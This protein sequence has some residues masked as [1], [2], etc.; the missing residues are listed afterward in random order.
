MSFELVYTSARHGLREGAS[1]FC[2]VAATDGIPRALHEKLES[3]SGYSH[4]EAAAGAEPPVNHSHLTIRIQRNI[5][6]IVSRIGDAGIDYTGRTN[7]IAHHLALSGAEA[8]RLSHGPAALFADYGFWYADWDGEPETFS[9]NRIPSSHKEPVDDFG[10]WTEVFGDAGW[11]G[12]LGHAVANGLKS[13]SIIVPNPDV[14]MMLLHE[15]LLLVSPSDRWKVCF[16]TYFSR[17]APG[18]QCHWRFVLD[19]TSEA[20]KLRARSL[21]LLVDPRGSTGDPPDGNP[22]V[23]AARDNEPGRVHSV[24]RSTTGRNGDSTSRSGRAGDGSRTR[25]SGHRHSQ[26]SRHPASR[27][28]RRPSTRDLEY[29]EEYTDDEKT[30]DRPRRRKPGKNR[31][32]LVVIFLLILAIAVLGFLAIQ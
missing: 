15:A 3:L 24:S 28:A 26:Q 31:R 30:G 2:T 18:T 17:L 7:K 9:P 14:T 8:A 16:S 27:G 29:V 13:V 20:R 1:G 21:G 23:E 22:F 11:A 32:I 10:T 19:G 12:V 25:R 5:Y 6:H 4:T